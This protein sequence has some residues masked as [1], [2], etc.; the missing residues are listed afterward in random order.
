MGKRFGQAQDLFSS[1][2]HEKTLEDADT[3]IQVFL[4]YVKPPEIRIGLVP[5]CISLISTSKVTTSS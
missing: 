4:S 1:L 3:L 5:E 2:L